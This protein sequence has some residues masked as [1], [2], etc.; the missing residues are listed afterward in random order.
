MK[1]I[2]PILLHRSLL[3][4]PHFPFTQMNKILAY[5]I[6]GLKDPSTYEELK[7]NYLLFSKKHHPD[8][9][10]D[11]SSIE[12]FKEINEAYTT[13]K[14]MLR[15][16]EEGAHSFAVRKA[17]HNNKYDEKI[18]MEEFDIF[19][20]YTKAKVHNETINKSEMD[21]IQKEWKKNKEEI[22]FEI[23]G[24]SYQEAPHLFWD[25]G[26]QNLR[27][28]YE[29]EIEKLFNKKFVEKFDS[30]EKT[31]KDKVSQIRIK[32]SQKSEDRTASK[33]RFSK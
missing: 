31:M 26:N 7:R 27:E 14:N 21:Q 17:K 20:K 19:N 24:K 4:L 3:N 9:N 5:K 2:F 32:A 6:L 8:I 22:F 23:F 16:F 30:I 11:P 1:H 10:H 25:E 18:S 28:I 13:L 29:D 15:S 33:L 12:K